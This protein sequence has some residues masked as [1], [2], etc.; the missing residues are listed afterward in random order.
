MTPEVEQR[1]IRQV[2]TMVQESGDPTG[3]DAATWLA[4]W[5]DEP[6]APLGGRTPS[7]LLGTVEGQAVVADLLARMQSGAYS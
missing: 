5:I 3:F 6:L 1:L 2:A 7:E 4:R